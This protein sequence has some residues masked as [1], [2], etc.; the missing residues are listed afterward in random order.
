[1]DKNEENHDYFDINVYILCGACLLTVVFSACCG[2]MTKECPCGVFKVALRFG[3]EERIDH[4]YLFLLSYCGI[5]V[6]FH[7]TPVV[8]H[9]HGH[10]LDQTM[11]QDNAQKNIWSIQT[12]G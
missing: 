6:L 11:T 10:C 2:G 4:H 3:F 8:G 9:Q 1:M 12:N 5:K 7:I